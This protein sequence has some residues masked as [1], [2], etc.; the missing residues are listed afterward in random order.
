M[1]FGLKPFACHQQ[2]QGG[3]CSMILVND[4]DDPLLFNGRLYKWKWTRR[5]EQIVQSSRPARLVAKKSKKTIAKT[6][7]LDY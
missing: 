7:G 3:H 6:F 5:N 1:T 4:L 2:L